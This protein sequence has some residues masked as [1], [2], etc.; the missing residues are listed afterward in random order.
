MDGRV[1]LLTANLKNGGADPRALV[2]ILR[3]A[4]PDVAA[5][6]EIDAAQARAV[7]ESGLFA[8]GRLDPR[9]DS[10]GLGL[11]LRH[12]AQVRRLA[13]PQR[14]AWIAEMRVPGGAGR[15]A[16]LEILCV[17]ITAPHQLP[18][19][20]MV[21]QRRDQ[22]RTLRDHLARAGPRPRVLLG[23]LNSTAL[24]PAYRSLTRALGEGVSLVDAALLAA[25]RNGHRP[26]LTWAPRPGW[27]R[28][29][30]IDHALVDPCLQ[31][32]AVRAVNLPGSDHAALV[33][34]V[35]PP[36]D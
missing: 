34:D 2:E 5:F 27:P 15:G 16:A 21:R 32:E 20:D 19:W 35:R 36:C 13:L 25:S 33:V 24:F 23:D 1:R 7:E 11:V 31:V 26:A 8:H 4:E 10:T 17:H 30:R 3:R 28:L 22:V 12:P 14:D 6:Q 29:L 9:A 18:P